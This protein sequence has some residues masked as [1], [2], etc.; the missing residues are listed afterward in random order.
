MITNKHFTK[1]KEHPE[2]RIYR[3]R[4][5]IKRLNNYIHSVFD[6][7]AYDLRLNEEGKDFLFD[8]VFNEEADIDFSD[9]LRKYKRKYSDFYKN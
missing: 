7:L 5:F 4:E 3:D 1:F 2:D 6:L 8:Y 9:F